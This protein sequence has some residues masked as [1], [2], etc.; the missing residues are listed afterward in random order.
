MNLYMYVHSLDSR[1]TTARQHTTVQIYSKVMRDDISLIALLYIWIIVCCSSGRTSSCKF[2][3]AVPNPA[4]LPSRHSAQPL[5]V[6]SGIGAERRIRN[7]LLRVKKRRTIHRM[8]IENSHR[9]SS[10][11][12]NGREFP[13]RLNFSHPLRKNFPSQLTVHC[14][15]Y[16]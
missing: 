13:Y 11:Q 6:R 1:P 16:M 3:T 10:Y 4:V 5:A 9:S 2:M 8:S 15:V 12:Q 7:A 14:G